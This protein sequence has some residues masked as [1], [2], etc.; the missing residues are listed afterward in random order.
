M[1]LDVTISQAALGD[2]VTVKT[3][4]GEHELTISPGIQSGTE[5]RIKG[6][7]LPS[8]GS[9]RR[10][11]QVVSVRVKTPTELSDRQLQLLRELAIEDGVA[12]EGV[13]C[14]VLR[15]SVSPRSEAMH[16][17]LQS[18]AFLVGSPTLNNG[19]FPTIGGFLT[20]LKGLRPKDRIAGAYGSCGWSG[21]AVKQIDS[22]LRDMGLE[23]M[24]PMEI[25]Y[26][27]GPDELEACVQLG[28]EVA[29]RAKAIGG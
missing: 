2:M 21:G 13:D 12:Q 17:I 9:N 20:Y 27:P 5:L 8:L 11:D 29:R 4:D 24:D 1:P 18:R 23:V 14:A 25:K 7:G 15:M 22:D 6:K 28:R 3:I 10:G 19:V 26:M 16:Q